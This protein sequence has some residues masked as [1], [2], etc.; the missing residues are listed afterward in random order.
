MATPLRTPDALDPDGVVKLVEHILAADVAGLFVLGTTGEGPFLSA[1]LRRELVTHACRAVNGRV[2]VL[3]GITDT[4]LKDSVAL[5]RHA[6][7]RGAAAVV[8]APPYYFRPSPAEMTRWVEYLAAEVPVPLFLYNIPI[9]TKVS[10]P[11]DVVRRAMEMKNVVGLKDS[12]GDARYLHMARRMLADRDDWTLLVGPEHMT[13]DFVLFGGHG[14]VNGGANFL[15]HLFVELYKAAER[16]DTDRVAELQDAV[17]RLGRIYTLGDSEAT[18]IQGTKAA[19]ACLG[20]C[21]DVMAEPN[22]P[23]PHEGREQVRRLLAE[24]KS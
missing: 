23:L 15:P 4:S 14:G 9:H 10:I 13:A 1:E 17:L 6:A 5:A 20:L 12:S 16:R 2:P 21:S 18:V 11:F 3:V 24:A 8:A 7:D 22:R 19:L